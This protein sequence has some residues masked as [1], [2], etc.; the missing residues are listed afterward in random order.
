MA[1]RVH[2]RVMALF[3]KFTGLELERDVYY[4]FQRLVLIIFYIQVPHKILTKFSVCQTTFIHLP[5]QRTLVECNAKCYAKLIFYA[6]HIDSIAA[7]A[8]THTQREGLVT[9]AHE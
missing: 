1:I 8:S 9:G 6:V 2:A 3:S 7:A 5:I 4:F